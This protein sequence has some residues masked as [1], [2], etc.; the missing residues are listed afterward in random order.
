MPAI[1]LRQAAGERV[2]GLQEEEGWKRVLE[3]HQ[4]TV[5][6]SAEAQ[7]PGQ[8]GHVAAAQEEHQDTALRSAEAELPSQTGGMAAAPKGHAQEAAEG[9]P[10]GCHFLCWNLCAKTSDWWNYQAETRV[11]H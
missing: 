9:D 2:L 8:A 7:L 11:P 4:D 3:E 5:P 10:A 1:L 6:P